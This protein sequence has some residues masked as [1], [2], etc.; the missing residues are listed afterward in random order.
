MFS[1]NAADA[2]TT[3]KTEPGSYV[4]E[5]AVFLHIFC[6]ASL[7]AVFDNESHV[8]ERVSFGSKGVFKL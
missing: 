8:E 2:T 4:L 3:L 6:S 7:C 1:S 5:T